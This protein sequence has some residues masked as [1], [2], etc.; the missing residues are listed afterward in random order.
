M[1]NNYSDIFVF[2]RMGDDLGHKTSTLLDPQVIKIHVLPQYRRIID[3]VHGTGKQFLLHSCGK[4]F[5]LMEDLI[6]L[7]IDAKHSNEDQIAPFYE[8]I[9]KYSQRIGLLGGFD[10]NILIL[11]EPENIFKRVVEEGTQFR[12][13]SNGYALGSGNS[14]PEYV[15]TEGFMAMIEAVKEIRSTESQDKST[16]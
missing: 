5:P 6:S 3:L 14:I 2:F 9:D 10:L 4:I 7:G 13:L 8:W 16:N 12:N 15:P 1:I 11:E